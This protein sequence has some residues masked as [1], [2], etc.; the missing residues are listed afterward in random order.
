ML[1]PGSRQGRAKALVESQELLLGCLPLGSEN[2]PLSK[3][4]I[5]R[6]FEFQ[7]LF[8]EAK[9]AFIN[10]KT[11]MPTQAESGAH[12]EPGCNAAPWT[13]PDTKM[14]LLVFSVVSAHCY[15]GGG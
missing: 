4:H 3:K 6:F 9:R 13:E 8:L 14:G 7:L 11:P 15:N 10:D 5:F 1:E 12:P 2:L